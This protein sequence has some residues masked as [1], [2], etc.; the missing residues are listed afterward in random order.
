MTFFYFAFVPVIWVA[1]RWG[2]PGTTLITL[3]IQIALIIVVQD[4]TNPPA[5]VDLQF[6]L[7][8]LSLT[9]LLLGSVVTERADALQRV[10]RQEAEQRTLLAT[11]PDAVLTVD[12][13]GKIRSA[14]PAALQLFGT[15]IA[16][17]TGR[18]IREVLPTIQLHSL[19]GRASLEGRRAEGD[20]FPADIAWARLEFPANGDYLVIIRDATEQRRAEIQLRERDGAL[21]RAMRFAVAGELASALAHELNQP[22]TALVSYIQAAEILAAPAGLAGQAAERHACQGSA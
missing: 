17:Q 12:L 4:E 10:A 20:S 11:A 22:I 19:Q 6:L 3:V 18:P 2:G 1:L 8:T 9:A 16:P 21:A 5:L 7:L 14:N 15:D 13:G